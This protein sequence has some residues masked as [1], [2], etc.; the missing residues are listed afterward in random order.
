MF[1]RLILFSFLTFL[2]FW[3][4]NLG[5]GFVAGQEQNNLEESCQTEKIDENCQLFSQKE[6][7]SLLEQCEEYFQKRS[8]EY[9]KEVNKTQQEKK[10]LENQIYIL[11]N[12]IKKLDS[13]IKETNLIIKDL[14]IQIKNAEVSID[15]TSKKIEN[16]KVVLANILRAFYEENEKSIIEVVLSEN[17]FSTFFGNLAA[18]EII[19]SKNQNL[20]KEIKNLKSYLE[21]QKESYDEQKGEMGKVLKIN[22]LQKEES[23]QTKSQQEDLLTKTKGKESLYQKLLKETQDKAKEI[24]SRIF[25]V[26]GIPKAPTFGEAYELAKSVENFT[27]IRPAFLLAVLTQESKIGKNVGQCFLSDSSSGQGVRITTNKKEPRTMNPSRD[28]PPF[29]EI[30]KSLGRDPY[31]TPVSCPMS[32]GW[33]GAMGPAQFIPSTWAR[34]KSKIEGVSGKSPADPWDINDAFIAAALYLKN[35]GAASQKSNDEWKAAMIY[36]SGT[37][38][39]KYR[40]YGNSVVNL[41]RQLEEDIK[42]IEANNGPNS[43]K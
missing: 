6:C 1:K 16:S 13:Q 12:K 2:F 43:S 39:A 11:K 14:N 10:T 4:F 8:E 25:E 5:P 34:Y 21:G 31:D 27:G 28:V 32:Y 26:I 19:N 7:R 20:L 42:L 24:R 33:G 23:N 40:F 18:L 38:S 36:F 15:K 30:T 22:Q 3:G 41:A 9:E 35:A 29:L 17:K 37:T